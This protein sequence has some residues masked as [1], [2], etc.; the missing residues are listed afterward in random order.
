LGLSMG[1][2][3][4]MMTLIIKL[5]VQPLTYKSYLSSSRMRVLKPE[6]AKL[7]EKYPR[8]E[9]AMKKQQET[10]AIYSKYGVSPMSGCL[11]TLLQMPIWMALFMFVP[12]AIEL[13]QQ[14]FLWANDLSS[15]DDLIHWSTHIPF[16]GTHLSLFCL[17]MTITNILNTKYN[18]NQQDTGQQ[19]MPGMKLMMYAMP[20]MFIFVLNDYASGLNYYYFLS[21]LISII[22]MV[23]MRKFVNDDKI[24]SQLQKYA[25]TAKPKKKSSFMKKL[26][27][28]QQQQETLQKQ[29][30]P[31][32]KK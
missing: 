13:R 7:A 19:Q 4:F 21:G 31:K 9:D 3:L 6:I 28:M 1:M 23:L 2:V 14:S 24:L 12:T 32:T 18:M 16:L 5:A 30:D 17:L 29:R 10:M 26:E 25:E 22:I 20:V 8:K 11:P 15:Y 27:E